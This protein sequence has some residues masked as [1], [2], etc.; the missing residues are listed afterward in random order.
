[1]LN[2]PYLAAI[3]PWE[4]V[5][6]PCRD[7]LTQGGIPETRYSEFWYSAMNTG[8]RCGAASLRRFTP[9]LLRRFPDFFRHVAP[10]PRLED[11]TVPALVGVSWSDQG[12]RARG[13]VEGYRRIGSEHKWL[14]THGRKMWQTFYGNEAL[15][16]Q[17]RF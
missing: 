15:D 16:Y 14:Y 2:P 11:V 12:P 9:W 5:S 7:I 13:S 4:G 3:A 10:P 1:A 17:R 8:A 6:D